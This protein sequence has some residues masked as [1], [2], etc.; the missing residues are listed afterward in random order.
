MGPSTDSAKAISETNMTGVR[1][2][3]VEN[4]FEVA[5][6]RINKICVRPHRNP[7]KNEAEMTRKKPIALNL[8]SPATIIRTP[9][10]IEA[11][12]RISLMDGVSRRNRTAKISTKARAE[13]LHMV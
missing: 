5:G 1:K 3:R 4:G 9:R 8:V 2:K 11:M 12:I 6:W 13:D 7:E 10:V